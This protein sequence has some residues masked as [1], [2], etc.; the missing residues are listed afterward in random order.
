M[1]PIKS[2]A[3]R[4][5][6]QI[7]QRVQRAKR[8]QAAAAEEEIPLGLIDANMKIRGNMTFS[9]ALIIEGDFE[10]TLKAAPGSSSGSTLLLRTGSNVVLPEG[11]EGIGLVVITGGTLIGD[12]EADRIKVENGGSL[13]GNVITSTLS[14]KTD[15]LVRGSVLC[16]S[17]SMAQGATLRGTLK[18][19]DSDEET[20]ED[21]VA[22]SYRSDQ[23]RGIEEGWAILKE[24]KFDD[25][26]P[27]SIQDERELKPKCQ[28]S[29]RS[30]ATSPATPS[31]AS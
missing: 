15:G 17:L 27:E 10:G 12:V 29:V 6:A 20:S 31:P 4:C 23:S 30:N 16:D 18:T 28:S 5:R 2:N 8:A 24:L 11:L 25:S 22:F 7:V 19:G 14:I 13:L 9:G 3:P 1:L 26:D 21:E